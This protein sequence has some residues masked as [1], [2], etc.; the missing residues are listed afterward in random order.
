MGALAGVAH[1]IHAG[2]IGKPGIVEALAEVAPVTAIRGNVD[3]A[4]WAW[5]YPEETVV[6]LAGR[7]AFVTHD[8]K[9][10]GVL[11]AEKGIDAV[12]SGHSH[13]PGIERLDGVLYLNPGAAGPRRFHLPVT[14]GVMEIGADGIGAEI[15]ELQV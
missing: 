14:V 9:R 7:R 11:P 1:I 10:I 13:Q 3:T 5:D 15:V 4:E 8:R 12:I 6:E 2:D